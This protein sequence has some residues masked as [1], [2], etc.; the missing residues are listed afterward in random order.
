MSSNTGIR[1]GKAFCFN[2]GQ[3]QEFVGR[4]VREA[5]H[6]LQ[7]FD[8]DH[9]YCPKTWVEPVPFP[10]MDYT[11]EDKLYN[12]NW[13]LENG[14]HG[15][16]SLFILYNLSVD[17]LNEDTLS[18]PKVMAVLQSPQPWPHD[19][20]DFGRCYKLLEAVPQ[21]KS[22]FYKMAVLGK[23]WQNLEGNWT[24]LSDSYKKYLDGSE[25]DGQALKQFFERLSN[26]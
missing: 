25:I 8:K 18:S 2:C 16:S 1:N 19:I 5:A 14:E 23:H 7:T 17:V 12:I 26:L 13:W 22:V 10:K 6:I 20:S 24:T 15:T 11:P 3:S 21:F 9:K 4:Q